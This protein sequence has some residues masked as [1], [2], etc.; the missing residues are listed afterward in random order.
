MNEDGR[1][2]ISTALS[3]A[4]VHDVLHAAAQSR[5]PSVSALAGARVVGA[6]RANG[7]DELSE[8]DDGEPPSGML[9][10]DSFDPRMSRSLLRG[11]SLLTCFD[12]EGE[13]R[14]IVDMANALGM[15][16]SSAHRYALTLV[17]LG[18]LER[19]PQ[20]RKYSLP[21]LVRDENG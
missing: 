20:T 2:T 15:S 11:L 13:P 9:R 17:H 16:P 3:P 12:A 14:G 6:P 10:S 21:R 19:S 8:E 7:H 4:R 18:L 1:P 5:A